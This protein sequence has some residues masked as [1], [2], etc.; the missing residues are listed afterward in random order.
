MKDSTLADIATILE[1]EIKGDANCV[2]TGIAP[3]DSAKTGQIS[4]LVNPRYKK[5]LETTLASA[6]ILAPDLA[7]KCPVNAV[8]SKNPYAAYARVAAL[9]APDYSQKE[10][11]HASAVVDPT[12][13]I[14]PS[15]SIGANC[16]VGAHTVIHNDVVIRAGS[17]IES[18]CRI[19]EGT[20]I[21]PNVTIYPNVQIA[22]RVIIHSGV[23][24]GAD[25]FGFAKDQGKWLKIPQIGGVQIGNDVEIG[26]NTTIDR[27]ALDDTIISDGVKLDNQ[28]QIGH[29]VQIGTNTA[30]AGCVAIAGSSKLGRDCLIGGASSISGHIEITDNVALTG[31]A[32]VARS[33]KKPGM[34]SSGTD[35]MPSREWIRIITHLSKLPKLVKRI[36]SLEKQVNHE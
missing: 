9:F 8:I 23:V 15:A 20:H 24:I 6:V 19:D 32:T 21:W 17:V 18:H 26:A 25:G 3:L 28:I 7:D 36:R 22:K 30:I 13:E 10:G 16:V 35:A 1:A 33:I 27:G 34:Y 14:H 12:A 5:S 2:I 29:N 31:A 11:V 4:F